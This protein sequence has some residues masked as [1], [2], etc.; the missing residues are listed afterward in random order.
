MILDWR[1]KVRHAENVGKGYPIFARMLSTTKDAPTDQ[2]S[3]TFHLLRW[4]LNVDAEAAEK[5]HL[6]AAVCQ[7]PW[8]QQ[9]KVRL[10]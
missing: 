8:W 5:V 2:I 6:D 1:H 3:S 7:Q 10:N 9:Y 4:Q